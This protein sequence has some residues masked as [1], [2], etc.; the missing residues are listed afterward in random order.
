MKVGTDAMILGVLIDSSKKHR[1][2]DIGA[3]TGVL[4]LMVAQLNTTIQID[5]VEI[6][7]L[8]AEEC[9]LNFKNSSWSGRLSILHK[10]FDNFNT[11]NKYDLIFSNPPYYATTNLNKDTRKAQARHEEN[12][13]ASI[14]LQK[15]KE[16]LS[17]KGE[18]WVIIPSSER[19]K[20]S[21]KAELNALRIKTAI[22]MKGKPNKDVNRVVLC[23]NHSAVLTEEKELTVRNMDNSYSDE[24]IELTKE[25][26]AIDL[27][28]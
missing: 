22:S 16:L 26:H 27:R 7:E 17:D 4:S 24:Y 23:L 25:F 12:L 2:L 21:L 10:D 15:V 13:P 14:I 19:E 3:G 5:A 11:E 20:W 1:G 28:K 18:F 8:A 9:A 6:D